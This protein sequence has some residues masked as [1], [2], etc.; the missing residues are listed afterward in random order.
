[1]FNRIW[2]GI[3]DKS[4]LTCDEMFNLYLQVYLSMGIDG[5]TAEIGVYQGYTSKMIHTVCYDKTHYCYDTF[6]GVVNSIDDVDI[7]IV[8]GDFTCNL[9]EVK[10]NINLANVIYKKG[11]FPTT[12]DEHD[13]IFSIVYSDIATYVGT[14]NVFLAFTDRMAFGGKIIFYIGTMTG[15][16]RAI[17]EKLNN[18]EFMMRF[19]ASFSGCFV[20]FTR[21]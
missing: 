21:L 19:D 4:I 8:D 14:Q 16:M 11:I 18:A 20:I 1:M 3:L 13:V 10:S 2:Q 15:I 7:G 6:C 12:F 5:A 9:E 17:K